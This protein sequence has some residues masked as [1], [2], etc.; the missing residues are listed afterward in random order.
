MSLVVIALVA[1]ASLSVYGALRLGTFSMS[2]EESQ[3]LPAANFLAQ[4]YLLGYSMRNAT[5]I[6]DLYAGT[7]KITWDGVNEPWIGTYLVSDGSAF[8]RLDKFIQ[9]SLTI[10]ATFSNC[11]EKVLGADMLNLT[12]R[13]TLHQQSDLTGST[14]STIA[15]QQQWVGVSGSWLIEAETWNFLA[16]SGQPTV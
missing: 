11:T 8:T 2:T 10:N 12:F 1:V 16:W 5:A 14:N 7:A 9:E 15:V 13:L 3:N 4:K 6:M